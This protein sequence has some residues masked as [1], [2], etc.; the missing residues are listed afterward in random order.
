MVKGRRKGWTNSQSGISAKGKINGG[1]AV[2]VV[3]FVAVDVAFDT[4]VD[5]VVGSAVDAVV[6]SVVGAVVGVVIG[7]VISAV[8]EA[9]DDAVAGG[10]VGVPSSVFEDAVE[11]VFRRASSTSVG[12][13]GGSLPM[14]T[15]SIETR[16]E[17]ASSLERPLSM[18][19][20]GVTLKVLLPS[21]L[22][23]FR[24]MGSLTS[25]G[26]YHQK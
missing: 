12:F 11:V 2:E 1:E 7:A 20:I 23:S 4:A 13:G 22:T 19:F 18:S 26:L 24:R 21:F 6:D 8:V 3:F 25:S 5:V 16:T 9:R 14:L 15:L 10:V 17:A